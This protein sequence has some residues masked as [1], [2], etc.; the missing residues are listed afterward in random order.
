QA[1]SGYS[2]STS[3]RSAAASPR[4]TPSSHA[5]AGGS[6]GR[7]RSGGGGAGERSFMGGDAR[8]DPALQPRGTMNVTD[9]PARCNT[10]GSDASPRNMN[11]K[12]PPLPPASH[13][14]AGRP[15]QLLLAAIVLAGPPARAAD[16]V[17][18]TLGSFI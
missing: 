3:A 5:S 8:C 16:L 13:S 4:R 10:A 12:H 2:D 1:T 11:R 7:A 6:G 18:P 9:F 14:P 15:F 17:S